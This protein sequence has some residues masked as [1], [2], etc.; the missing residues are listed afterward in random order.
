MGHIN[1]GPPYVAGR[2][3]KSCEPINHKSTKKSVKQTFQQNER[4]LGK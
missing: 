3:M 4:Y 2:V 1:S